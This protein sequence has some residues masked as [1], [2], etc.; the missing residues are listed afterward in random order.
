MGVSTLNGNGG[1]FNGLT[2]ENFTAKSGYIQ[3]LT[4]GSMLNASG[5]NGSAGGLFGSTVSGG[6]FNAGVVNATEFNI[7]AGISPGINDSGT[8][9]TDA[10]TL[11]GN[12]IGSLGYTTS[13]LP[14]SEGGGGDGIGLVVSNGLVK[15][16]ASNVG[17]SCNAG[18]YVTVNATGT[19]TMAGSTTTIT[20]TT[21][22]VF[23]GGGIDMS[24]IPSTS[25][26]GI[27]A[28]FG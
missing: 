8:Q 10:T 9:W 16:T 27:Y 14:S 20:G 24:A 11:T 19:V 2:T 13:A 3:N 7:Y 22:V 26:T 21:K 17:M 15:A 23:T 6:T 25:Q 28:R 1:N 4:V 18:N 5:S 12:K